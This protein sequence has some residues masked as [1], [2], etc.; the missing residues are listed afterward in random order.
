[1]SICPNINDTINGSYEEPGI[2]DLNLGEQICTPTIR[3]P[4][5]PACR[6]HNSYIFEGHG[7]MVCTAC[8]LEE[9]VKRE[10]AAETG[11]IQVQ[12]LIIQEA[13]FRGGCFGSWLAP[14]HGCISCFIPF[15]LRPLEVGVGSPI[16]GSNTTS[17]LVRA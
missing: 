4:C 3:G 8:T 12:V 13:E 16:Q 17:F 1:M 2:V 10:A 14:R 11:Q 7:W 15:Q 5:L 9:V 6:L